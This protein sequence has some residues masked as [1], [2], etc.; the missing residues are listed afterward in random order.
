MTESDRLSKIRQTL[1][2]FVNDRDWSKFHD[3]KNLAMAVSSEAGELLSELRWV[4]SPDADALAQ[5]P[6]IRE[7][8]QNETADIAI[9]LFL[10][11]DR[12]GFDLL[13]AVENKIKMNGEHYP[14]DKAKGRA[15]R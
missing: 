6:E 9:L 11:C 1:R 2:E 5:I 15:D 14:I 3:P 10:F 8:L 4:A 7:R 12:I 13:D